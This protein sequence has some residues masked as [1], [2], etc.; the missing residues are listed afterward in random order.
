M[1]YIPKGSEV[2]LDG[3]YV[4]TTIT[5]FMAGDKPEAIDFEPRLD[6]G[7]KLEDLEFWNN[8]RLIYVHPNFID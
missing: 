1:K 7:T 3:E 5:D 8:G 2:L 4:S 6:V